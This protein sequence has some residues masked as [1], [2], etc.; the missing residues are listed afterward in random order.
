[1][2]DILVIMIISAALLAVLIINTH[3]ENYYATLSSYGY[4]PIYEPGLIRKCA[5]GPYM[6][7]SNPFMKAYCGSIPQHIIKSVAC[8]RSLPLRYTLPGSTCHNQ[9]RNQN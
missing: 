8:S 4:E 9:I 5:S 2:C 3:T 7:S 1:M 6:Y